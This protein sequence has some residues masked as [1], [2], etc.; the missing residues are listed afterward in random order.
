[1]RTLIILI[2]ISCCFHSCPGN[3]ASLDT[4]PAA[5]KNYIDPYTMIRDGQALLKEG[6]LVVRLNQDP[7]S[8]FIKSVSRNDK[9]YSHAG[10]VLLENGYPYIYHIVNGEENPDEKL[11]KDSLT[12]FCHPGKNIAFGIFRYEMEA[13][14]IKRLKNLIHE[15]YAKGIQFD[16]KFDLK[17]DNRM[18]C[19]EMIRKVVAYA[20]GKRILIP[21]IKLSN[22]EAGIFSVYMHLPLSYTSRL[23]VV[24]IDNLYTNPYC[25]LIKEYNYKRN[26]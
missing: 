20:T 14:E 3:S 5:A 12:R 17:T 2:F 4:L 1:M 24:P 22:R 21:T 19:S 8:H 15:W 25:H 13:G 6:D 7:A 16:L 18:Y 23:N 26:R 9:S 10:I 11:R